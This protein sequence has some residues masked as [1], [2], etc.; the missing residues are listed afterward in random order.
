[1]FDNVV[2]NIFIGLIFIFLLYS[3]LASILQE[4]FASW[5]SLRSKM[6]QKALR[7]MLLDQNT[8]STAL[9]KKVPQEAK[10]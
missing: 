4:L 10:K 3:L 8:T 6:L 1:M 7:R 5:C 2:L 9:L